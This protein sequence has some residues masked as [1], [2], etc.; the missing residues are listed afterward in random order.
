MSLVSYV[1][2]AW[3]PRAEWLRE[4]VASVLAQRDCEV[5]LVVVDDGSPEPV[6]ELLD[7]P[8]SRV[9]V[10]RIEHAGT[11]EA[12]NAG[13][14]AARGDHIRFLDSDDVAEP[15]STARL[16]ALSAGGDAIAYGATEICDEQLRPQWTMTCRLE[17]PAAE[18]C[19]LGRFTVRHASMLFPRAV[20]EAAGPW[21]AL[22][23]SQDW[24]FVL[25]ALEHAP[26]AR[27]P[28]VATFYRRHGGS[29]TANVDAGA[30]GARLVVERY[31]ERHPE[32][33]GTRLERRAHA[34]REALLARTYATRGQGGAA[35]QAGARSL[36]L[37]PTALPRQALL[38][39]P[40]LAGPLRRL[41]R[42]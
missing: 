19:L 14:A 12:R 7:G 11:G 36:A 34:V 28:A 16:L 3:K 5:E 21:S 10:V 4:A 29:A 15:G 13:L 26:V 33:R 2:P 17:G 31:F 42:R 9:R 23:V 40:G 27:D 24:D 6:K 30:E 8:D 35:L 38:A 32:R 22:R 39:L 41:V 1:M 37:D 20:V 18:A 25:R